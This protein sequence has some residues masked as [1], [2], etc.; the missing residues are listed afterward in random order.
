MALEDVVYSTYGRMMDSLG[1]LGYPHLYRLWNYFP[2]INDDQKGLERYK[3]FC[4]GRHRAFSER[5]TEY[6]S[7]LPAAS[8]VGSPSGP[9]QLYFLAGQPQA[10]HIENP[11]QMS[12][13]DYPRRYGPKS[14]SFA[15]A[16]L[17]A[18]PGFSYLFI[19]GTASIVG[20]ATQH[21]DDCLKQTK[22][23]LSNLN[24]LIEQAKKANPDLFRSDP[25]LSL[26]K[27]YVRHD[28]HIEIVKATIQEHFDPP[29]P[30]LYLRGDMCRRNLLVEIEALYTI[31]HS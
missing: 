29:I 27:I 15:R 4:V 25:S 16:T 18:M 11:R 28:Y 19:A 9:F 22:E 6:K 7:F 10:L 1:A 26:L 30:T 31:P 20:H 3:R 8:A 14:P 23:T 24:S 5:Y 2:T 12:A 17:T 21:S 13:Y